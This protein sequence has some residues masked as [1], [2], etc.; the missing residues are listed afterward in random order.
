MIRIDSSTP[1]GG[2]T[3]AGEATATLDIRA[4][5]D[6]DVSRLVSEVER[7]IDDP[8]VEVVPPRGP[9]RPVG[10]IG[11]YVRFLHGVV[12]GVSGS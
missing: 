11:P 3:A 7:V 9:G 5:P 1:D 4:L 8:L 2:E 10:G 12:T 6:E